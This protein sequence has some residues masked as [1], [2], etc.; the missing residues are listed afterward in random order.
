[1]LDL[2]VNIVVCAAR[3]KFLNDFVK[4][5]LKIGF[6]IADEDKDKL[7]KKKSSEK[8]KQ[9]SDNQDMSK[10]ILKKIDNLI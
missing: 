9:E 8:D 4:D 5:L 7:E 6:N 10:K 2:N 1:M 3:K